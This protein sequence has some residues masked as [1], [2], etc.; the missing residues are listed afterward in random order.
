MHEITKLAVDLYRGQVTNYSKADAMDV[1]RKELIELN[2]GSEK[3]TPKSFRKNPELFEI[4][5]EALD[6]LIVEGL[7]SQFDDFVETVVLDWGDTKVFTIQEHRLFDVAV[8]SDGNSDIR[9][10]RLD[11]GEIT[12]KTQTMAVAI[13][14]EL[15]RLLA[16]RVDWA[17]LV[18]NVAR[19]YNNKIQTEIYNALYKSFDK[20]SATYGVTGTFAEN[21]LRDLIAH[22][23]AGTG[24]DAV[25]MGTKQ[26]LGKITNSTMAESLKE[27]KARMGYIGHFEGTGMIEVKQA[28]KPGTDEFAIDNDFLIVTP[29][30]PDKL[31][32][33]VLEG[34]SIIEESGEGKRKDMQRD[35]T[36]IKKAGFAVISTSKYG[37]YRLS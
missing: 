24:M 13:Y 26:A 11:V 6:I 21:K 22:V 8:V 28:H 2:G 29:Q 36:F 27:A 17:K 12:V 19:S 30:S 35:Y 5:E 33:L 3:L 1:L 15:H 9:R 25:I 34:D 14:E 4:L 16:G 32:K 37:I 20:L 7:E 23:E 18:D 31:V 10:D